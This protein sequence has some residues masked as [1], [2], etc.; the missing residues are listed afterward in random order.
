M[1]RLQCTLENI[2]LEHV[3]AL[4]SRCPDSRQWRTS[5]HQT[6][7]QT[8]LG[9]QLPPNDLIGFHFTPER[10]KGKVAQTKER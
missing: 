6:E 4:V 2:R 5:L 8:Y 10:Y 1:E 7:N 9:I 3:C